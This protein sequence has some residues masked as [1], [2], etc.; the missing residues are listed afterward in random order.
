MF[1]WH[2]FISAEAVEASKHIAHTRS[3]TI[4]PQSRR[5]RTSVRLLYLFYIPQHC[6][7]SYQDP[8]PFFPLFLYFSLHA[9]S[10][11]SVLPHARPKIKIF[12][13][14]ISLFRMFVYEIGFV[15]SA[16]VGNL[17]FSLASFFWTAPTREASMTH[18]HPRV[19]AFPAWHREDKHIL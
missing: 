4:L 13:L 19:Y 5:K 6:I 16:E 14:S 17:F 2:H 8:P 15:R 11:P 1:V 10:F 18:I 3:Y 9:L 12:F 7:V